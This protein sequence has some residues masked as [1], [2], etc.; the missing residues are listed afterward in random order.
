[1]H[2]TAIASL[3]DSLAVGFSDGHVE[4]LRPRKAASGGS[5]TQRWAVAARILRQSTPVLHLAWSP[6][7][8]AVA[9]KGGHLTVM[10]ITG[11]RCAV[12]LCRHSRARFCE[13]KFASCSTRF[14]HRQ[15]LSLT[16]QISI[17]L[18]LERQA[19]I[20]ATV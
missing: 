13:P 20:I 19:F 4:V 18:A 2:V 17:G 14:Y 11:D 6:H 9:Q 15:D 1:M 10:T 7:G 12:R 8:L 3:H 16:S 5:P